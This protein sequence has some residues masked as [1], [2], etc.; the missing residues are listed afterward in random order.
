M[1][2]TQNWRIIIKI[3]ARQM[4]PNELQ[5]GSLCHTAIKRALWPFPTASEVGSGGEIP[6]F[7]LKVTPLSKVK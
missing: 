6:G 4:A 7:W 2:K 1:Q 5:T 3:Q